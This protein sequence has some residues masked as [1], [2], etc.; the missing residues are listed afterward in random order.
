MEYGK[1]VQF[2]TPIVYVVALAIQFRF[3]FMAS[4]TY[5]A[6]QRLA[7]RPT[8]S[9]VYGWVAC[10]TAGLTSSCCK[11]TRTVRRAYKSLS[12]L[13]FGLTPPPLPGLGY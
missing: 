13:R 5:R 12:P 11:Q 1:E 6:R 10:K 8:A 3:R 7:R 4:E 2:R 9:G